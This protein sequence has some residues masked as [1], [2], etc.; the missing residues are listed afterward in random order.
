MR[1][2]VTARKRK[3]VSGVKHKTHRKTRKRGMSGFG[4]GNIEKQLLT[5][6]EVA[7]GTVVGREL[8]TLV[9]GFFPSFTPM[10]S[11][12]VQTAIGLFIP[13]LVKNNEIAKNIGIGMSAYGVLNI[14]VSTG[15]IQG[16]GDDYADNR[17]IEYQV[18][19]GVNGIRMVAGMGDGDTGM[20]VTAG[21]NG[22]N[23]HDN[24]EVYRCVY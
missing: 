1:H 12:A 14:V 20:A 10:V 9:K 6:G 4:S 18:R 7:L 8:N 17:M 24:G 22:S 5:V 13:M 21:V 16:V 23:V 3:A 11:G 2:K 15:L 19:G